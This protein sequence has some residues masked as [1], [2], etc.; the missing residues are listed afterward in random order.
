MGKGCEGGGGV[1]GA[2]RC[3]E[4]GVRGARA[5]HAH[6]LSWKKFAAIMFWTCSLKVIGKTTLFFV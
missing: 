2:M 1:S 3:G 4:T 5:Y 6:V